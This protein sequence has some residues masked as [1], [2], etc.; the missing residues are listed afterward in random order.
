MKALHAAVAAFLVC[1][2]VLQAADTREDARP[3]ASLRGAF[4][5]EAARQPAL[6]GF[7]SQA[8]P[9]SAFAVT[10]Q[11]PVLQETRFRRFEIVFFTSL[12]ASVLLSLL[13]VIA[14]RSAAGHSGSFSSVEYGYL[15]LS[16]VGISLGI[17]ASDSRSARVVKT[18]R[19]G[20][21]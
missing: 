14:F 15:A 8:A 6:D 19:R 3:A 17:A 1:S 2:G 4:D 7:S 21:Q 12:P 5:R 18:Y 16:T 20:H 13:G 11:G 10:E 9:L